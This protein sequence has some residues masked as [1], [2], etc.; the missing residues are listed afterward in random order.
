LSSLGKCYFNVPYGE[1][2]KIPPDGEFRIDV[3]N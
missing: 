2:G 1:W 3:K